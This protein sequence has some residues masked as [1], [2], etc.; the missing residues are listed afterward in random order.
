[1]SGFQ[2][3]RCSLCHRFSHTLAGHAHDWTALPLYEDIKE[4]VH[5]ICPVCKPKEVIKL[6]VPGTSHVLGF[7]RV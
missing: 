3:Y 4:V 2:I 7:R 1:M 5:V 6:F